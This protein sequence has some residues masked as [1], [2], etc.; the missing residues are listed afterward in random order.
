VAG[1]DVL[2]GLTIERGV[3]SDYK[4]LSVHHY[5]SGV[6]MGPTAVWT[7][8][9][10][11]PTV[12]GQFVQR[13]EERL[14]AGVVVCTLPRL[15]CLLRDVAT[16]GRYLGLGYRA[17][18]TLLNREVRTIARVVIDPRLRGLGLAVRLVRHT[19]DH[20][21]T[22]YTEALAAMGRVNPFFERAGMV[23][24]ERPALPAHARLLSALEEVG[25][26][27][28]ELASVDGAMQRIDAMPGQTR[29]LLE[30]ELRRWYAA[31]F[32]CSMDDVATLP[33]EDAI[34]QARSQLH[35]QAV[36]YLHRKQ[37]EMIMEVDR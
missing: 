17:R 29:R 8:R 4:A 3:S 24:Y 30:R 5:K 16:N 32:F 18:A 22:V 34:A 23:R 6:P 12:V 19:L 20:A 13:D 21:Q 31:A 11:R 36:Y 1:R 9:L 35:A 28:T 14:I 2:D 25:L 15:S 10:N 7:A 27:P 26:E 37:D 33:I